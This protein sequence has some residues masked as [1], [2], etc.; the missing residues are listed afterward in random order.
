MASTAFQVSQLPVQ[1]PCKSRL[2]SRKGRF[3]WVRRLMSGSL[4]PSQFSLSSTTATPSSKSAV[5][6]TGYPGSSLSRA[7]HASSSSSLTHRG[8]ESFAS[9]SAG[10]STSGSNGAGIASARRR[11][12]KHR[13]HHHHSSTRQHQ[14]A[15]SP[16][17][18]TT[19]SLM[20]LYGRPSSDERDDADSISFSAR[21]FATSS[22]GS[23][24]HPRRA[25]SIDSGASSFDAASYNNYTFTNVFSPQSAHF[26]AGSTHNQHVHNPRALLTPSLTGTTGTTTTTTTGSARSASLLSSSSSTNN[27]VPSSFMAFPPLAPTTTGS[28]TTAAYDTASVITLASSS[29]RRR[30]SLDT[31]ASTRALAPESIFGASRESLLLPG[32]SAVD[33]LQRRRRRHRQYAH[34]ETRSVS[35]SNSFAASLS[36]VSLSDNGGGV[37]S[38]ESG[39]DSES[40]ETEEQSRGRTG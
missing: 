15:A 10:G 8:T 37:L 22:L 27:T 1:Q 36:R 35:V 38:S 29:K 39:S 17:P 13:Q 20:P 9:S 23:G 14:Y 7:T 33:E 30:K 40:S 26:S 16:T 28:S 6:A 3:S 24:Y 11:L 5:R 25:N 32:G 4:A 12:H 18:T 21:S 19:S 31:N 34:S 2:V